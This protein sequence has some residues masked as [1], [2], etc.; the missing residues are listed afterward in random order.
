M[1][2]SLDIIK[3]GD[4]MKLLDALRGKRL[5]IPAAVVA[6]MIGAIFAFAAFLP[7]ENQQASFEHE[8]SDVAETQLN[9]VPAEGTNLTSPEAPTQ[10]LTTPQAPTQQPSSQQHSYTPT[11]RPVAET[12]IPDR[13]AVIAACEASKQSRTELY[14]AEVNAEN[15][16]HQTN[17]NNIESDYR[18]RGLGFSGLMQDALNRED[19]RYQAALTKLHADYQQQSG[20]Q[21]T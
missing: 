11:P 12:I 2:Y 4:F 19:Q 7:V 18:S 14:N 10:Q 16:R 9:S 3:V 6:V 1:C 21:C 15:T 20:Q 5:L 17:R 8:T 13:S